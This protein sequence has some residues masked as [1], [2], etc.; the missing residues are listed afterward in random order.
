[1]S[2]FDLTQTP[3]EAEAEA[4]LTKAIHCYCKTDELPKL[5]IV[6]YGINKDKKE[7]MWRLQGIAF[8]LQPMFPCTLMVRER[9]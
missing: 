2:N 5:A 7:R 6:K 1:M 3:A 4:A 8:D 9:R